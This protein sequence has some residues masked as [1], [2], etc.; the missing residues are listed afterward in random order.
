MARRFSHSPHKNPRQLFSEA[1]EP[2]VLSGK[3]WAK[4]FRYRPLV[5]LGVFWLTLI[6]ISAVA[7][8]RLMFSGVPVNSSAGVPAPIQQSSPPPVIRPAPRSASGIDLASPPALENS[9]LEHRPDETEDAATAEPQSTGSFW[10]RV[11][12]L[13]SLVGLCALGSFL[14]SQQAKRPPRPAKKKTKKVKGGAK[15]ARPPKPG[16]K[17]SPRPK[18]LAPYAP[19]RDSVIVP[20]AMTISEPPST[21]DSNGE[22][23]GT[24]PASPKMPWVQ[25]Q[26]PGPIN[27]GAPHRGEP[28][29]Q[30]AMNA[31][32]MV[33]TPT[34]SHN[35]DIVPDHEDHPLDWSEESIAHSLDLRHRR[36][37]SSFM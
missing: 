10:Q 12:E 7:Y 14:I 8:S 18:R 20:G 34:E 22:A 15:A 13:A 29:P 25:S 11:G 4:L 9:A 1:K 33:P 32:P 21:L 6:C 27:A 23:A 2:S 24:P 35:P 28:H 19:E 30:P 26:N 36:S 5:L 31:N 17:P 3:F 37:L 16:S